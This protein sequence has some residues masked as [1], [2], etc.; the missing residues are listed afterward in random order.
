MT[1]EWEDTSPVEKVDTI[2]KGP[3]CCARFDFEGAGEGDLVF[4]EGDYIR[5]VDRVDEEWLRGEF[6]GKVGIF[7]TSFVEIIEDLPAGQEVSAETPG[8]GVVT[9]SGEVLQSGGETVPSGAGTVTSSDEKVTLG[10]E[11]SS[12]FD[13]IHQNFQ[14]SQFSAMALSDYRGGPGE[15][16]LK[17]HILLMYSNAWYHG[18]L[19]MWSQWCMLDRMT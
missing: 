17:V 5:L 9:P 15:L 2:G 8:G 11:T 13:N 12:D 19:F 18:F 1:P 7:P 6:N 16:S 3:R 4:E 14:Q 10:G